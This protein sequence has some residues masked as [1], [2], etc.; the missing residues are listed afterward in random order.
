MGFSANDFA[1]AL[2]GGLRARLLQYACRRRPCSADDAED[3]VSEAVRLALLILGEYDPA[4]GPDGLRA[5]SERILCI[6]ILRERERD[7]RRVHPEPIAAAAGVPDRGPIGDRQAMLRRR[8]V[9]LPPLQRDLV[10]DWLDGRTNREL[11]AAYRLH[12]N[13][14][15]EQ[16]RRAFR[17]LRA[18]V[19]AAQ[20]FSFVESDFDACARVTVYRAPIGVWPSW[21][22]S[23]PP[24]R[25][26]PRCLTTAHTDDYRRESI[27]SARDP[28]RTPGRIR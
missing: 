13:W 20:W 17:G 27:D 2:S 21:R 25:R 16:L 3:L 1:A 6:V 10:R 11:A 12:R 18:T 4:T 9:V 24:E 26:F 19:P 5:W 15:G 28:G 7:G 14:I 8:L 22:H 23:H